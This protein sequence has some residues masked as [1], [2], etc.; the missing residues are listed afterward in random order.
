MNEL[1]NRLRLGIQLFMI[2]LAGFLFIMGIFYFNILFIIASLA[3]ALI[4]GRLFCGWLCPLGF[5]TERVLGKITG[6]RE[7]PGFLKT[8]SF[9]LSFTMLFLLISVTLWFYFP[10]QRYLFP[11]LLMGTMFGLATFLGM[12]S[13]DK[14]WCAY[15]CP[16]GILSSVLGRYAPYQLGIRGECEG[17]KACVEACPID[18]VPEEAVENKQSEEPAEISS[19]CIRCLECSS[20]CP[21]D[22]IDVVRSGDA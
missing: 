4:F 22:S 16:W 1:I 17:C 11:V 12:F 10:F 7:L 15:I 8:K 6:E 19:R 2:F 9:R 5:W 3:F 18:G 21:N 20:V 14:A 13:F